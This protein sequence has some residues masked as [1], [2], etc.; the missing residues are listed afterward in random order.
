MHTKVKTPDPHAEIPEGWAALD[1]QGTTPEE[2][3]SILAREHAMAERTRR[4]P[5]CPDEVPRMA[6]KADGTLIEFDRPTSDPQRRRVA[7]YAPSTAPPKKVEPKVAHALATFTPARARGHERRSG[8][9]AHTTG[10]RRTTGSGTSSSGEDDP[11]ASG[12]P[13]ARV[14]C[15][16][17]LPPDSASQTRYCGYEDCNKARQRERQHRARAHHFR[18]SPLMSGPWRKV[19]PGPATEAM[20]RRLG[21]EP[22]EDLRYQLGGK[23]DPL[24]LLEQ[25]NPE[26][27]EEVAKKAKATLL[28]S[29]LLAD[30]GQAKSIDSRERIERL[31]EGG[32]RLDGRQYARWRYTKLWS[33]V[34]DE[35]KAELDRYAA[36]DDAEELELAA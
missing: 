21:K 15:D 23:D 18:D 24:R 35:V 34:P 5:I 14:G 30:G 28:A 19:T 7:T 25:G 36:M 26:E 13:C 20:A 17:S 4:R 22:Q 9:N 29:L 11:P 33:D 8:D 6:L 27:A 2:G 3:E 10:S 31:I 1:G 32:R 16:H 12:R